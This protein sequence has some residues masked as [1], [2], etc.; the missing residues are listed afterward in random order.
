MGFK[1]GVPPPGLGGGGAWFLARHVASRPLPTH[2]PLPRT[3]SHVIW[4]GETE[5]TKPV[6]HSRGIIVPTD[7]CPCAVFGANGFVTQSPFVGSCGSLHPMLAVL[8][9]PTT[10]DAYV[11]E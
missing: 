3:L 2:W 4:A 10:Q 6:L 1:H 7:N 9:E 11:P 8:S 5:R